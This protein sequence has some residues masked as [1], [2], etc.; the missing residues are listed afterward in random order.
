LILGLSADDKNVEVTELKS[1]G[2]VEGRH[3]VINRA[4]EF[5]PE[6]HQAGLGILTFFGTVLREKYP[7]HDATV[8]IE[9]DG[10]TVRM[11]VESS[12]GNREIIEKA[13]HDY[14]LVV[15]GEF[16]A[17]SLFESRAKVLELKN[18]LRIAHVRI[19]SQ[20][21]L[22]EFQG[23][24]LATLKQ[25]IGQA[26]SGGTQQPVSVVV[27]PSIQ[28]VA[29]SVTNPLKEELPKLSEYIQE[30]VALAKDDSSLQLRLLDL[31][32]TLD[33]LDSKSVPEG[34]RE[35]SGMQKLKRFLDEAGQTG[36]SLNGL[37][38]KLGDGVS[39]L[40]R[41][42]RGYNSIAEWCGAP[43]VPRML[44]GKKA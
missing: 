39:L 34:L 38:T 1:E 43:Q 14:E 24:E 13:L 23:E 42:A 36:T 28:V 6:Y 3:I 2:G 18:E 33:T 19:E 5:P 44:L 9:Q 37:I 16:P 26:L 22:L 17:E 12:S 41:I 21:E 32:Q 25:L 31:D 11:I 4:I 35:S 8:K 7:N 29:S 27:S 30:L 20:R 15:R 40:Q 10:L